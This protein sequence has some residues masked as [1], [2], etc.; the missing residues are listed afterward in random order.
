MDPL[1]IWLMVNSDQIT[2]SERRR[3]A[4][5]QVV[6]NRAGIGEFMGALHAAR[7]R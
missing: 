3:A 2:T 6:P 7:Q 4:L 1:L 5:S